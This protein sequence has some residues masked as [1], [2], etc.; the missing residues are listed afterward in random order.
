MPN[1][2]QLTNI[3]EDVCV[4]DSY[5]KAKIEDK[6]P[7]IKRSR[8]FIISSNVCQFKKAVK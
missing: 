8:S 1:S 4:S 6:S 5:P 7:P 2:S 3:K